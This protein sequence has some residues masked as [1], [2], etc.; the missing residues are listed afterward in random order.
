MPLKTPQDI[1]EHVYASGYFTNHGPLAKQLEES[2]QKFFGVEHAVVVGNESLALVMALAG[3]GLTGRVAVLE[4]CP[5]F[6]V[7]AVAWASLE[8]VRC[9]GSLLP[10]DVVAVLLCPDENAPAL[11]TG[12]EKN[13]R[14]KTVV[15]RPG[16][17]TAKIVAKPPR[18]DDRVVV[19]TLAQTG[20]APSSACAAIL[21]ADA[22]LAEKYRNIRS[23]YGAR[24]I[25]DVTAT[26]NGRV[27]EFQAGLALLLLQN[28]LARKS[29]RDQP[30]S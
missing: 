23:S 2:L 17:L 28:L 4:P 3:L 12:P 10:P 6:A 18:A 30:S 22:T 25:V 9:P 8:P 11:P 15:Y 13:A 20:E 16:P 7:S 5:P 27:S 24:Q 26:A 21:T 14:L 29:P 19:T 1:V